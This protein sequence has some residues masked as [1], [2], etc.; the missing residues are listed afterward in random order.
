MIEELKDWFRVLI[1]E[2]FFTLFSDITFLSF[3][4]QVFNLVF[5]GFILY[6]IIKGFFFAGRILFN[7][8]YNLSFVVV[9][10]LGLLH[11]LI[12]ELLFPHTYTGTL[13]MRSEIFNKLAR[14]VH[15]PYLSLMLSEHAHDAG[16][17][18]DYYKREKK[19]LKILRE[20]E[21]KDNRFNDGVAPHCLYERLYSYVGDEDISIAIEN[22]LHSQN[23][24]E[25]INNMVNLREIL[26][27]KENLRSCSN[28]HFS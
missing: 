26:D 18:N 16:D 5:V 3:L 12:L 17:A 20:K 24:E 13:L 6:W 21:G 9:R 8:L 1:G 4:S 15:D 27:T 19:L 10:N 25:R 11:K 2:E 28:R 22:I 14:V 7:I 23:Q